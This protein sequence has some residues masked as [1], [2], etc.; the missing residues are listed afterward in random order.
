MPGDDDTSHGHHELQEVF[1]PAF[2]LQQNASPITKT[3]FSILE[4][5][6]FGLFLPGGACNLNN[7]DKRNIFLILKRHKNIKT[8]ELKR[9]FVKDAQLLTQISEGVTKQTNNFQF[10]SPYPMHSHHVKLYQINNHYLVLKQQNLCHSSVLLPLSGSLMN[11][12][13]LLYS[14]TLTMRGQKIINHLSANAVSHYT[15]LRHTREYCYINI[16]KSSSFIIA[17]FRMF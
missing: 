15:A 16:H 11:R 12:S 1:R 14:V 3:I 2:S 10:Y 6:Q 7:Q 13:D 5:K 4:V 9:Q 17:I 8:D